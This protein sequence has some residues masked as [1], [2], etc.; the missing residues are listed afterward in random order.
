M[1]PRPANDVGTQQKQINNRLLATMSRAVYRRISAHL[2]PVRYTTK[3]YL[4][5]RDEPIRHVHFIESGVASV[6]VDDDHG[7]AVEVATV[8]NEG[9]VGTPLLLGTD[10]S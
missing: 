7:N 8:G 10:R 2:E 9:F 4:Y 6:V 3:Q 1:K 5:D